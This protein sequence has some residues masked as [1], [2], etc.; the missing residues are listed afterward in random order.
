MEEKGEDFL[1]EP[2]NTASEPVTMNDEI[3]QVPVENEELARKTVNRILA[4][5]QP[6]EVG[7]IQRFIDAADCD[8]TERRELSGILLNNPEL[9]WWVAHQ[10]N[11]NFETAHRNWLPGGA[12]GSG[13]PPGVWI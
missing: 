2:G 6:T 7:L 10:I 1:Q 8:D 5:L 13:G 9:I 11:E 12:W 3:V 4:E